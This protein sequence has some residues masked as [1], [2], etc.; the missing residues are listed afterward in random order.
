MMIKLKR[1]VK[2]EE[3]RKRQPQT[4]LDRPR[5]PIAPR[6]IKLALLIMLVQV[7]FLARV[8]HKALAG[9]YCERGWTLY[10]DKSYQPAIKNYSRSL[11]LDPDSARCYQRRAMAYAA[12]KQFD[13]ALN[14][15]ERS[16]ELDPDRA[17]PYDWRASLYLW[18]GEPDKAIADYDR[19]IELKP[20]QAHPYFMRGTAYA[21]KH[22][23]DPA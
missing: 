6:W 17:D 11:D 14:D 2:N 16:I 3:K 15:Y 5:S 4:M 23:Q 19:A 10:T 18:M 1:K 13:L 9:Y 22:E 12:D 7:L 8:P 21:W 20:D